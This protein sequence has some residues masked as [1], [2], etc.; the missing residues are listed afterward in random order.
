MCHDTN[1]P[2]L[3][4][5]DESMLRLLDDD[6][7]LVVRGGDQLNVRGGHDG[8]HGQLALLQQIVRADQPVGS[9]NRRHLA[10][11]CQIAIES[12]VILFIIIIKASILYYISTVYVLNF[13]GLTS[14][15]TSELERS[16]DRI[17]T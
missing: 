2:V 16:L 8:G 14:L 9:R 11:I 7:P 5:E 13:E 10:S 3:Q 15:L 12:I 4:L 17:Q 1:S 6:R